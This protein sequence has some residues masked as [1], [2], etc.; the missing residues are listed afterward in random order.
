MNINYNQDGDKICATFE[1]FINPEDSPA[2]FWDTEDEARQN[3]LIA[4]LL[5]F[6]ILIAQK[7]IDK[8]DSWRAHSTETYNDMKM[9]K[10]KIANL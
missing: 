4:D 1:D 3:L 7:F 5:E 10:T 8:V 6:S 9:L 2:G